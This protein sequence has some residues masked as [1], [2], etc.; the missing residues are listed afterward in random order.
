MNKEMIRKI[1]FALT[2]ITF[3]TVPAMMINRYE[4]V[5]AGGNLYRFHCRPVDP[6]D[7]FRGKYVALSFTE[8]EMSRAM[9]QDSVSQDENVYV[10]VA[11]GSDGFAFVTGI[12]KSTPIGSDYFTAKVRYMTSETVFL[13]FPFK[14]YYMNEELAP[15][16]EKA[17]RNASG[18]W[19]RHGDDSNVYTDVRIQDGTPVIE[20]I[21]IE[22]KPLKKYLEDVTGESLQH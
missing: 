4:S 3:V 16:A 9:V 10:S 17:Y 8:E 12:S 20:D 5:M 14:R 22:G 18:S 6:Y 11:K 7:S 2:M 19:W 1:A 15:L 13:D 21:Y